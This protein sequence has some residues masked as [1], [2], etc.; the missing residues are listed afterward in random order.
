MTDTYATPDLQQL[1]DQ[2][3]I[4]LDRRFAARLAETLR[5]FEHFV[6]QCD[7][8]AEDLLAHCFDLDPARDILLTLI[9]TQAETIEEALR[10]PPF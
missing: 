10:T 9:E 4:L 1:A 8:K 6:E 3:P 5:D 2:E 7:G